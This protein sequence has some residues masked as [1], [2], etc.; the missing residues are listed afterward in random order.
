M[1]MAK[2]DEHLNLDDDDLEF[3]VQQ[4][5]KC[6]CPVSLKRFGGH[7][8]LTLIRWNRDLPPEPDNLVLLMQTEANKLM[9]LG[10]EKAFSIEMIEKIEERLK[11][12]SKVWREMN[13]LNNIA[14]MS[15]IAMENCQKPRMAM[16]LKRNSV[17]VLLENAIYASVVMVAGFTIRRFFSSNT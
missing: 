5:W 17:A 12:A 7:M 11:W 14:E 2:T 9:E 8:T 1:K 3:I 15:P 13:D 10:K 6:R 4:V 16:K